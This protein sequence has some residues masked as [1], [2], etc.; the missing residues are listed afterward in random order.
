MLPYVFKCEGFG[1]APLSVCYGRAL[2]FSMFDKT[3]LQLS[4]G[5]FPDLTFSTS[6][7]NLGIVRSNL[8]FALSHPVEPRV[9]PFK[10]TSTVVVVKVVRGGGVLDF[11]DLQ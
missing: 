8:P 9:G 5:L 6:L 2:I 10:L 1:R 3:L 11:I 7:S 4:V